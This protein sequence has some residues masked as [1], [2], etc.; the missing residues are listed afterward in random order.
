M[1]QRIEAASIFTNA[2][3]VQLRS[4]AVVAEEESGDLVS[5][6]SDAVRR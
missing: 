4:Q 1:L 2:S 5:M 3:S 6:G